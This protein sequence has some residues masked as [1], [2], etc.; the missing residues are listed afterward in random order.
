MP[1]QL[2]LSQK[3]AV[4]IDGAAPTPDIEAALARATVT[5]SLLLPDR[6]SL[7]YLDPNRDIVSRT[8]VRVGSKVRIRVY[9]EA[10]DT[11]DLVT[12]GEVTGIETRLDTRGTFTV[13]RG[14]DERHRLFRGRRTREFV[15]MTY[16]DVA[17]QVA[18]EAG[19]TD[20]SVESSGAVHD[21]LSQFDETDWDLLQRL[22][23]EI[24]FEVVVDEGRFLFRRPMEASTA[25][26]GGDLGSRNPLQL[27]YGA[28]LL[29]LVASVVS[30][31][32]VA[33]VEVRGWDPEG[34]NPL[35][36]EHDAV[37]SGVEIGTTPGE[38]AG[39]FGSPVHVGVRPPRTSQN[40]VDEAAR[41]IAE[42]IGGAFAELRG[43]ARGNP[44]LLAGTAVSLSQL[45]DPFDGRYTLTSTTHVYD[46]LAGYTVEFVVSGREERSLL[47]I[48]GAGAGDN[49]FHG[50]VTAVVTDIDDPMKQGRVRV[51]FPWLHPDYRSPWART[52]QAAAGDRRGAVMLPEVGDEVLVAFEQ[53]SPSHPYV[54]GGLWSGVN[55]APMTDYVDAHGMNYRGFV[56]RTGSALIFFDDDASD[57]IALHSSDRGL[58]ISLNET[59]TTIRISSDGE[60]H[61]DGRSTVRIE[62]ADALEL[63]GR[64]V[65]IEADTALDLSGA[66]VTIDGSGPVSVSGSPIQLN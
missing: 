35:V 39:R 54:L 25:P 16:A 26:D 4:E 1:V 48:G 2:Q 11:G 27:A 30:N 10:S 31:E 60:V 43:T 50:V 66:Q 52:V 40:Q 7:T 62:S 45:G 8:R 34:Q 37:S 17:R 22:A 38:L 18:G 33:K 24:G 3:F 14:Y 49:R 13:V 56:S 41:A 64:S 21:H 15:Q 55:V 61:I 9:S 6:F 51:T 58:R 19:F 53:G 47:G 5:D 28:D 29:R 63:K 23:V 65:S 12:S 59:D 44:A 57:G 20:I 46:P 32:Q 36:G 42:R